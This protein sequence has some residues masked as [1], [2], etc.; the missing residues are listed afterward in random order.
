[1]RS[2]DDAG[3]VVALFADCS[4]ERRRED[5]CGG[6]ILVEKFVRFVESDDEAWFDLVGCDGSLWRLRMMA[7]Q[8]SKRM[9]AVL[10]S[11]KG[12]ERSMMVSVPRSTVMQL[13]LKPKPCFMRSLS[14]PLGFRFL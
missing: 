1:L 9:Q 13:P 12:S 14:R 4:D 5:V 10:A 8:M 11:T 6:D 7:R 3:G 2:D